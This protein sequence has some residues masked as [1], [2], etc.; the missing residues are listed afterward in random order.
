MADGTAKISKNG[1]PEISIKDGVRELNTETLVEDVS[2]NLLKIIQDAKNG[3]KPWDKMNEGE[4]AKV[5]EKIQAA[6]RHLVGGAVR[7]VSARGFKVIPAQVESWKVKDGL[8]ITLKGVDNMEAFEALSEG[9]FAN[10]V[11]ASIEDFKAEVI[12][13]AATPDQPSLN[14]DIEDDAPVFDRTGAGGAPN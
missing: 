5:I 14:A 13:L 12:P 10:L 9:K 3:P 11:F 7:L 2:H 4:Q 8:Q 6:A 1:G